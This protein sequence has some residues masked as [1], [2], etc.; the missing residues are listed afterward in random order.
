MG[1]SRLQAQP[2]KVHMCAYNGEKW[3]KPT[4]IWTRLY[5]RF[6]KPRDRKQHCRFCREGCMHEWRIIRRDR[7]DDRPAPKIDGFTG[8]A[9]K[10]RIHPDLAEELALAMKEWRAAVV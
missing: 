5:P 8:E 3:S 7:D 4:L 2:V 9:A 10:N 1:P 6:W